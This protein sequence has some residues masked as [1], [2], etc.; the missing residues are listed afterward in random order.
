[1][2]PKLRSSAPEKAVFLSQNLP[3]RE[4]TLILMV[5][6]IKFRE[7]AIPTIQKDDLIPNQY[8]HISNMCQGKKMCRRN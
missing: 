2:A 4:Y 8:F 3:A 6:S 7:K 1:M 5:Q